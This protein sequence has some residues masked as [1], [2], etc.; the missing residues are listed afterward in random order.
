M[1]GRSIQN[2]AILLAIGKYIIDLTASQR[3]KFSHWQKSHADILLQAKL[4]L[5]SIIKDTVLYLVVSD[6]SHFHKIEK[7][8]K[9]L[10]KEFKL[11]PWC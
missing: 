6:N 10:F 5:L 3:L 7:V 2:S 8:H 1:W 11:W 4:P 9:V